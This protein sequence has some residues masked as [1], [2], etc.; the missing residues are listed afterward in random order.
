MRIIE[1]VVIGK[2]QDQSLCEDMFYHDSNYIAVIDGASS[3][4]S[5][6]WGDKKSGRVAAEAVYKTMSQ[7]PT[8]ASAEDAIAI[9]NEGIRQAY[10]HRLETASADP[11]LQ[12]FANVILYSANAREIWSFGDC[13]G[14]INDQYFT[15]EKPIDQYLSQLRCEYLMKLINAG[16]KEDALLAHDPSREYLQPFLLEELQYANTSGQWG[17]DVLN[18][19]QI[20]AS[21]VRRIPVNSGDEI[22]LA[23]DGY[24]FVKATLAQSEA[25]L[26]QLITDDPLMFRIHKS[27]KG[28]VPGNRSFDDRTFVRFVV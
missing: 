5:S 10:G 14:R 22:I 12:M 20:N 8:E 16:Q 28:V 27:T 1:H 26:E 7:L 17:F 19:M 13:H 23:T 3:I 21:N 24:P 18:G 9:L 6:F 25:A 11:H 15:F 4:Q 2:A